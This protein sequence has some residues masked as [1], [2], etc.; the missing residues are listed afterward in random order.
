MQ[1]VA[2]AT[3]RNAH[4]LVPT[5]GKPASLTFPCIAST[6]L[7]FKK[8]STFTLRV[9]DATVAK[10]PR[11]IREEGP[12][13][14]DAHLLSALELGLDALLR[15]GFAVLDLLCSTRFVTHA[16]ISGKCKISKVVS[17]SHVSR[18]CALVTFFQL[19]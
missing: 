15:A 16:S 19:S 8:F 5:H 9:P 10:V 14:T 18:L 1:S 12:A 2:Y 6:G 11:Y 17:T 13:A 3:L 4:R 7:R